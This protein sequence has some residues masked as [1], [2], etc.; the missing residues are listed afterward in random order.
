MPTAAIEDY[1]QQQHEKC[2]KALMSY[3]RTAR[4]ADIHRVRVAIKRIKAVMTIMRDGCGMDIEGHF[5]VY[6]AIFRQA[7]TLRDAGLM[8][9]RIASDSRDRQAA[10]HHGRV[11]AA[12][13]RKMR[14]DVPAYLRDIDHHVEDVIAEVR[15]SRVDMPAY[16]QHLWHRLHKRWKHAHKSGHYHSLRKHL[17]QFI[18]AAELLPEAERR[19]LFSDRNGKRLDRLQDLIGQ[20]HDDI[21]MDGHIRQSV[22]D[23]HDLHTGLRH[24]SDKLCKKIAR[25]GD[26][27]WG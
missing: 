25:T 20:W 2:R 17:K 6:R 24:S 1:Y 12:L 8:R 4:D 14:D 18:Y 26:K 19:E 15:C 23:A 16:C 27:I 21:Y 13:S 9:D 11:V 7:G 10:A 22:S 5:S 3:A